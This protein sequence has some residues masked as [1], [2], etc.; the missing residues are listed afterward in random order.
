MPHSTIVAVC[1]NPLFSDGYN[2]NPIAI[3]PR[4]AFLQTALSKAPR[5]RAFCL[6]LASL[7]RGASDTTL[8]YIA[9]RPSWQAHADRLPRGSRH[10]SAKAT[11]RNLDLCDDSSVSG[12][13]HSDHAAA[14]RSLFVSAKL[15]YLPTM[16]FGSFSFSSQTYSN[17]SVS[18]RNCHDRLTVQGFEY[19]FGSSGPTSAGHQRPAA[20]PRSQA[21]PMLIPAPKSIDFGRT[22]SRSRSR[23]GSE[24]IVSSQ[25]TLHSDTDS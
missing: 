23:A 13:D 16:C 19:A 8:T 18:G 6:R 24:K 20:S 3:S 25:T 15:D 22:G 10:F 14:N 11:N 2:S 5:P 9:H 4:R 12:R 21:K 1:A 7:R 17:R